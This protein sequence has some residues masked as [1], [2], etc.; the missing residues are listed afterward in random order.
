MKK[1]IQIFSLLVLVLALGG[2]S[3]K[4]VKNNQSEQTSSG[5]KS[6]VV[7]Q[8]NQVSMVLKEQQLNEYK[9]NSISIK[10]P[11]NYEVKE[12]DEMLIVSSVNGKIIIGGFKPSVGY[13]EADEKVFPFRE[14][15]YTE[16]P[17]L[18]ADAIP[19]ALYY[20]YGDTKTKT[21]LSEI[22]KTVKK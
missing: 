17:K 19:A 6:E 8:Q 2:C 20:I 3:Y 5:I 16:N 10:Y 22:L 21:E 11:K 13:P 12:K 1:T 14:I 9:S 18:N 15:M 4:I 7:N